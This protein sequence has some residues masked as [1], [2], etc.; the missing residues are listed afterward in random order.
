MQRPT[1]TEYYLR[2]A[3][4]IAQ[5][6]TCLRRNYGA[7]IV[8]DDQIIST[9]Y[10]GL[11]RGMKNCTEIGT[12]AREDANCPPGQGYDLC[13]GSVH[14]EENAIINSARAGV[15][16]LGGTMYIRG[17]SVKDGSIV[18]AQPC[19]RCRHAIINAGLKK[20]IIRTAD[21]QIKEIDVDSFVKGE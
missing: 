17:Y 14:A 3:H 6:A 21:N 10:C 19:R 5:R 18:E 20:V 4:E 16:L 15:S 2:I 7:V 13:R 9:G 1:K 8:R 12:C 11:P